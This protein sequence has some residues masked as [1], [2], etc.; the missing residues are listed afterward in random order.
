MTLVVVCNH[1]S[2]KEASAA[3]WLECIRQFQK[4]CGWGCF[5]I[6]KVE[7]VFFFLFFSSETM[8]LSFTGIE[9][10]A[11]EKMVSFVLV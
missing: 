9:I 3:E 10:N 7:I 8:F 2:A 11:E 4:A 5:Y 1:R 6:S